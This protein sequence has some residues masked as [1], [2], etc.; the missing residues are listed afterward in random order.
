MSVPVTIFNAN[1]SDI[2]LIVNGGGAFY[3]SGTGPAANWQPQQPTPNPLS[4]SSG[5][6]APN[7]FGTLGP[8]QVLLIWGRG[9]IAPPLPIQIPQN[10]TIESLQLYIFFDLPPATVSWIMLNAG[11]PIASGTV[12]ADASA[13]TE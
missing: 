3:I 10:Q 13:E 4:F 6:P 11:Q 2:A 1:E 12:S 5:D 9:P 7:V 8:N